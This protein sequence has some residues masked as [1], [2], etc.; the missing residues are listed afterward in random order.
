MST[1][2][3]LNTIA[4]TRLKNSPNFA[5]KIKIG[6]IVESFGQDGRKRTNPRSLDYFICKSSY[7]G[8]FKK[9]IE[10][11]IK[12][13]LVDSNQS[14]EK[15]HQILVSFSSRNPGEAI[16]CTYIARKGKYKWLE[17]DGKNFYVYDAERQLAGK[18]LTSKEIISLY[19]LN[20]SIKLS[21]QINFDS[22]LSL[23]FRIPFIGVGS[24]FLFET[25]AVASSIPNIIESFTGAASAFDDET[26]QKIPFHL[27]VKIQEGNRDSSRGK[28]F[29]VVTLT[30]LLDSETVAEL[31]SGNMGDLSL[32]KGL[33]TPTKIEIMGSI[34][35]K[36]ETIM[37]EPK[38]E[39]D[40]IYTEFEQLPNFD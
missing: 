21:K 5:G 27:S 4:F 36:Q 18:I 12:R 2:N 29:P 28:K 26:F 35:K 22:H 23:Y 3:L 8:R 39:N 13:N 40:D 31:V 10:E 34:E 20:E 30:P 19:G 9:A 16:K 24:L 14:P 1:V 7:E 32:I 33:I 11:Q 17:G 37:L 6:E 38:K 25:K 15:P